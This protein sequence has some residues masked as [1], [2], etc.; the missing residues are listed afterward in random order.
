MLPKVEVDPC[1]QGWRT[2]IGE[3]REDGADGV[4]GVEDGGPAE[5]REPGGEHG[6]ASRGGPDGLEGEEDV[7][8]AIPGGELG[9]G[10]GGDLG[11]GDAELDEALDDLR[12]LVGLEVGPEACGGARDG[13]GGGEVG[14]HAGLVDEQGGRGNLGRVDQG[15]P[16][17]GKRH[18]GPSGLWGRTRGTDQAISKMT[19][20]STAMLPGSGPMPTA[21]RAPMPCSGPQTSAKSSLH[22]L[23]TLGWS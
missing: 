1:A 3:G 11:L 5:G 15:G 16:W 4:V 7:V 8:D 9:L 13:E 6:E 18:G 21:E 23:M 17:K 12:K 19:S 22:P 10:N 2:G 20:I 14:L